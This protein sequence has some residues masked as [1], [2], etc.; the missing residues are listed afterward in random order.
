M[1]EDNGKKKV[2]SPR[3]VGVNFPRNE[4]GDYVFKALSLT[5]NDEDR[6]AS[7]VVYR[8]LKEYFEQSG[9]EFKERVGEALKNDDVGPVKEFEPDYGATQDEFQ[10]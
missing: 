7:K 9:E 10:V 1:S 5:R 4:G 2:Q 8:I 6:S 3:T